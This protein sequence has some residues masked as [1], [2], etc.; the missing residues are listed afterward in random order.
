VIYVIGEVA[1]PKA[2]EYREG[3]T[4]MEVILEAGGFSKFA[5]LNDIS[6]VRKVNGKD[7]TITVKAKK[8]L[9]DADLS[10]NVKL[11]VGDYVI[12]SE[13]YF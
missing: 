2:I 8:L 9:K 11:K 7:T 6:I 12:V 1:T 13:S 3:V 4:V 5:S 10:Q